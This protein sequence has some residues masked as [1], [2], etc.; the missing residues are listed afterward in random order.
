MKKIK[1]RW[2]VRSSG[3]YW[4]ICV[5]LLFGLAIG[6]ALGALWLKLSPVRADDGTSDIVPGFLN[7]AVS[8]DEK[9]L[10]SVPSIA[11]SAAVTATAIVDFTEVWFDSTDTTHSVAWGDMDGDGDLDL[12]VGN[13][14][15]YGAGDKV[16]RVYRNEGGVLANPIDLDGIDNTMSVAWGDMDGD[17]D[18]D[19]AVGNGYWFSGEQNKVYR[20]D[21]GVFNEIPDALGTDAEATS[22]IA[23]GDMDGDGDLDLAVGNY[24][25]LNCLY[26]NDGSGSFTEHNTLGA[27]AE[28]TSSVAWGDM[29]GDGDLDL[30]VA[31][32]M[33]WWEGP[34]VGQQN[35]VYQNDGSG[36]FTEIPNALGGN[37]ERSNSVAWGDIDDDGDLDLAI[38]NL[39]EANRLYENLG[40]GN[41][42]EMV[43]ALD[44]N[45]GDTHSVA[46]G[47]MDGDGDLDLAVGNYGWHGDIRPNRVYE[48]LGGGN[49]ALAID[50]GVGQT[51]AKSVAWGDV[52]GDGDLDLIAGTE[53][54]RNALYR[55]DGSGFAEIPG[56]LGSFEEISEYVAWGDIDGDGDLDLVV[57]NRTADYGQV[58]RVYRNDGH[59]GLKEVPNAL[60]GAAPTNSVALGDMDGDGD[61]DLA[62][63][64]GLYWKDGQVNQIYQNDGGVFNEIPNTPDSTAECS[65]SIAWGDIDGDSDLDLAVGNDQC[66]RSGVGVKNR[67]YRNDGHGNFTE[68]ADAPSAA[69]MTKSLAFGDMD[70]DG[71]LDLAIGNNGVNRL[72]QNDGSGAFTEIPGILGKDTDDTRRVDWGDMDGDGDLDLATANYLAPS[73]IYRN[74]GGMFTELPGAL[75]FEQ[76]DTKYIA[77]GDIDGDGDLDLAVVNNGANYLYQNDGNGAFTEI[78]LSV[79]FESTSSIAWGDMDGDGDLD[80]VVGNLS[81]IDHPGEVNRVY[82]NVRG[83]ALSDNAPFD[84]APLLEV[85]APYTAMANFYAVPT[86]LDNLTIPFTYTLADP[87][88]DP[89]RGIAASY[90]PDGGGRWLPAVATSD[91]VTTALATGSATVTSTANLHDGG[92]ASD[93]LNF[94]EDRPLVDLEVRLTIS[95]TQNSQLAAALTSDWPAPD[96]S[97]ILLFDSVGD[98]RRGFNNLI[99]NDWAARSITT[100]V[101]IE[102]PV[103]LRYSTD[104]PKTIDSADP[105]TI[106][107]TL[108]ITDGP[109][110]ID[111]VDVIA[112]AGT[113]TYI[114]DL[115]FALQSPT[116]TQV[117][118]MEDDCWDGGDF[119]LNL[120]DES[121]LGLWPCPPIDG[122]T[123]LPSYP[124]DAFDD[125]NSNGTWTL[126]VSDTASA[127]GGSLDSW[128]LR[129]SGGGTVITAPVTGIYR[130]EES[131]SVL[132]GMPMTMPLTLIITDSVGG[133]GGTGVLEEWSL[134]SVGV[135]HVYTWDT[136]ASGFFGHSDNVVFRLQAN[137]A[138]VTN[139]DSATG[140]YSYTHA[141]PGPYQRPYAAAQIHYPFRVRGTQMRVLSTT[142]V[143]NALVYHLPAGQLTGAEPFSRNTGEPFRTDD[144]GYLQGRGQINLGDQLVALL[145]A[146]DATESCKSYSSQDVP[147][148]ITDTAPSMVQS[149]L[150]VANTGTIFDVNVTLS[151][152]HTW[153]SDLIFTLQSPDGTTVRILEGPCGSNHD[154]NLT[155]DD[156]AGWTWICPLTGG[157]TAL[158]SNPLSAFD[159]QGS[160]GDWILTVEDGYWADGGSLDKWSLEICTAGESGKSFYY[161]SAAPTETGLDMYTVAQAGV[162]TLTVSADNPLLLFNLDVSLEW[163]ARQD[164]AFLDQLDVN[165]YRVSERLFDATNGQAALGNVTIYHDKINWNN[166]DI[167]V[168]ASNA[169]IPNA[170]IGGIVTQDV[171]EQISVNPF[172]IPAQTLP[173][174]ITYRAGKVRMGAV[175]RRYRGSGGE[176]SDDWPRALVHELGHYLFYLY[177]NYLGLNDAGIVVPVATCRGSLM[178][179]SYSMDE[180]R[181]SDGWAAECATTMSARRS[182]RADWDTITTFYPQL[183]ATTVNTGPAALPLA[184]TQIVEVELADDDFPLEEFIFTLTDEHGAILQPGP[185]AQVILYQEERIVDLGRPDINK[186]YARGAREGDRLCVYELDAQP[187]RLGCETLT[188]NDNYLSVAGRENW[189][190]EVLVTPVSSSSI[191]VDVNAVPAGLD[192]YGRLYP[193]Q[194]GATNVLALTPTAEG[195]Q[196]FFT[197]TEPD[198]KGY[199]HIWV[200]ESDRLRSAASS[201]R[202]EVVTSYALGGNPDCEDDCSSGGRAP[203]GV[204][205][206]RAAE[207]QESFVPAISPD[208]QVLLYGNVAFA[209]GEFYALQKAT[210]LPDPLPWATVVGEGYHVLRSPGAPTLTGTSINFRYR[211]QDVPPGEEDFL[212]IYYWNDTEWE[213]LPTVRN[214][215]SN[216]V[217]A[218]SHGEGLYALMTSLEIP[219]PVKGWNLVSY[220]VRESRAVTDALKSITGTYGLVYGYD[221]ADIDKPWKVYKPNSVP[222][223]V[224]DL[225]TMTFGMGYW[226][227]ATQPITW[228]VKGE[229]DARA[230]QSAN[231]MGPPA[232]YYGVVS[233]GATFVP[234]A[235]MTVSAYVEGKLCGQGETLS[236]GGDIVYSVNV[237]YT[238]A[239]GT[240]GDS[241][242][243][244]MFQVGSTMMSTTAE[245]NNNDVWELPLYIATEGPTISDIADQST[246][247]NTP[248]T[249][250]FTISDTGGLPDSL[251][252]YA[253]SSNLSL[254]NGGLTGTVMAPDGISF[255]GSGVTR[256]ITIT[257]MDDVMG[258]STIT[259]TVDDGEL[260]ASDSFVFTVNTCIYLP[261]ILKD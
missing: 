260:S 152:T 217:S 101:G 139:R 121:R 65:S 170:D 74:D 117:L 69:D 197:L 221:A 2:S 163:D 46:L 205:A 134:R 86:I 25:G 237:G 235:G 96:G 239:G 148:A 256:T 12:A 17:G 62:V 175:W 210:L 245:W 141:A 147:Q 232:T 177:D 85:T 75:G 223:W 7:P 142:P 212:S 192:L 189:Q 64:N 31:N 38:G 213:K 57:A 231:N 109:S 145:P 156:E 9:E 106:T 136:F 129:I 81:R 19:L 254:V 230:P 171:Q 165:L 178:S 227:S 41:F 80:L 56:A 128:G 124:L 97:H 98:D 10:Y 131:L 251:W 179:N 208:G 89:V 115:E 250:T 99:L 191:K 126:I 1:I 82:R 102:V 88:G 67:L 93:T 204:C 6:Y 70:G 244:V 16:N 164:I 216:E 203:T 29:D 35:R 241:G 132:Q 120:D 37:A 186:V 209:D 150:D 146:V 224:N 28:R 3:R 135:T 116:G 77:W 51:N 90:S 84:N 172:A 21:G 76:G 247:I 176:Q 107:S 140:A 166:A 53:Y 125:E 11:R 78:V 215:D 61:L 44:A 71:D 228:E 161:A 79:A 20:N 207:E 206:S 253:E 238:P 91:T 32:G 180:F 160:A 174:T 194:G 50:L 63:A 55:N 49:F 45:A 173:Y 30:A 225:Y 154:F 167:Q 95:H 39:A 48:N 23:W 111:D 127:D 243:I 169:L 52:D 185:H 158:P 196:V 155:L 33:A 153:V 118:I 234:V 261:S 144:H 36:T 187:P 110:V 22:S 4:R 246:K 42:A 138:A 122:S 252:L 94:G 190:P 259:V 60:S 157:Q 218:L 114:G 103:I 199:I 68:I 201:P 18:L 193:G 8:L 255:S 123:Y 66:N 258:K 149:V 13:Y 162:Q 137:L 100:A 105:N 87:E 47:D 236:V 219:L 214:P 202:R 211:E 183:S 222:P 72:Y 242:Q 108:V 198:V 14:D 112:L 59:G 240:C 15:R 233:P 159:G 220:P 182:G 104:V 92:A 130:P 143:S 249:V 181:N 229:S 200:D 40:A 257:P 34:Q 113:H 248:V 24:N 188:P 73:I 133:G 83:Q 184:V 226:I 43:G 26:R 54:G 27:V 151:G 195:Y 5:L 168:Y 119:N 58:N